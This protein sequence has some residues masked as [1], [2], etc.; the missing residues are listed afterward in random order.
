MGPGSGWA[1][2]R[3]VKQPLAP[4]PSDALLQPRPAAAGRELGGGRPECLVCRLDLHPQPRLLL[5]QILG[6]Q[7]QPRQLRL[8][9]G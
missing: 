2:R 1:A 4:Q 5:L 3:L 8:H 6:M 7:P 9:G